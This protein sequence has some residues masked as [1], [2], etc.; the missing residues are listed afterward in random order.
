MIRTSVE[1][2]KRRT[3]RTERDWQKHSSIASFDGA[4]GIAGF[5]TNKRSDSGD[6][7]IRVSIRGNHYVGSQ[8]YKGR[9]ATARQEV[10]F[11]ASSGISPIRPGADVIGEGVVN[12]LLD[13]Y[14]KS[15]RIKLDKAALLADLEYSRVLSKADGNYRF[16]YPHQFLYFLARYF[17]NNLAGPEGTVLRL[18]LRE[19]VRDS[20]AA[21]TES[22]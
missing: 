14:A 2:L 21:S 20:I 4:L 3:T 7:L 17:K 15:F 18:R 1:G 22:S 9:Q 16:S 13:E 8:R 5:T 10:R 12:S 6:R 11:F 19:I